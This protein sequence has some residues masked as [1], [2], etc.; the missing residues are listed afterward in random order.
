VEF[1]NQIT[2][3]TDVSLSAERIQIT[4]VQEE[5]DEAIDPGSFGVLVSFQFP[6]RSGDNRREVSH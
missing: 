2:D 6:Q 4:L 3:R 1:K 5:D